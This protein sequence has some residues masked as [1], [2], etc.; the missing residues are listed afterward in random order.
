M[1]DLIRVDSAQFI[2]PMVLG[3]MG[4]AAALLSGA[5][6]RGFFHGPPRIR[7]P[8]NVRELGVITFF[9]IVFWMVLTASLVPVLLA[10]GHRS[11]S[12]PNVLNKAGNIWLA[13]LSP[14]GAA[15]F[16]LALH[17][18][19]G[20]RRYLAGL[21]VFPSLI[22]RGLWSGFKAILL[23][24]PMVWM[25]TTLTAIVCDALGI[26]RSPHSLIR[27]ADSPLSATMRWLLV[28]AVVV[29]APV[30][31]E[32]LF[33]GHLQSVLSRGL[34]RPWAAIVITSLIFAAFHAELWMFV[35]LFVLSC[36]FGLMYERTGNL[37]APVTMHAI[38]NGV[39]LALSRIATD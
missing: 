2:V 24:M 38:F 19:A 15:L 4:T 30:F 25:V 17:L 26:A 28:F 27:I 18:L 11:P 12:E 14:T 34:N 33:R 6:R 36:G 3:L 32:L 21:G 7:T 20:P 8:E 23:L 29:A 37:W 5:A 9:S 39:S 1:G 31:E 22:P 16:L 10:I 35:P 13:V